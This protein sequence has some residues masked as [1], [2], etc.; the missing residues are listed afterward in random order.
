MEML[1]R[2]INQYISEIILGLFI[3][4]LFAIIFAIANSIRLSKTI[5]K[6]KQLM[7]GMDNKNL[8]YMLNEHLAMVKRVDSR[9]RGLDKNLEGINKRLSNRIK[10][11]PVIR[12]NPFEE[13]GGNQ[14]FSLALLDEHGDGVVLTGLYSREGSAVFAKPVLRGRSEHPL[15]EEEK[16]SIDMALDSDNA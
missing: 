13:M 6:Y 2:I 15:S 7:R 3:I 1:H 11:A 10:K 14:S 9:V 12:Y 4:T 5:K 8:E 16:R